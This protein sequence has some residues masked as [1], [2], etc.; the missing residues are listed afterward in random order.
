V[1]AGRIELPSRRITAKVDKFTLSVS[2]CYEQSETEKLFASPM[3]NT[4]GFLSGVGEPMPLS[5][6][7]NPD[8]SKGKR[9]SCLPASEEVGYR[10]PCAIECVCTYS[11]ETGFMRQSHP[12]LEL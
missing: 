1:E 8:L 6:R 9:R 7:T 5:I 12:Q 11:F 4:G 3:Y 2:L 10:V